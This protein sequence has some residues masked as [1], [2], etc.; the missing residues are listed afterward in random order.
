MIIVLGDGTTLPIPTTPT[1][2]Y[3]WY[4]AS[5]NSISVR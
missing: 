5:E 1:K 3:T 2:K 4:L